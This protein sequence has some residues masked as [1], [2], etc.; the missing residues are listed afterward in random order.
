MSDP[1]TVV[2]TL[3]FPYRRSLGPVIGAF[4][5]AIREHR[6]LGSRTKSG[7]VLVPPHEY[8][9]ETGEAVQAELVEVGPA[10]TVTSWTWVG[11]PTSRHPIS[12][13]FA[14]ALIKL[15]GA[16]TALVHAVDAGSP[17]AMT[18]GM[19]VDPSLARGSRRPRHRHRSLRPGSSRIMSDTAEAKPEPVVVD[20]FCTLTYSDRLS[21]PTVRFAEGLLAGKFIGQKCPACGRVYLPGKGYC[22]IDVVKMDQSTEVN[23]ADEGTVT[24]FTIITPVR[25]FGQT[26]T[27]PFIYASVL[28]DGASSVLGGQEITG[29]PNDQVRVGLRVRAVWKPESERTARRPQPP[30]LG[31]RRR[32]HRDLPMDRRARRG[33]RDVRGVRDLM[34]LNDIAIVGWAQTPS[35]RRTDTTET[36]LCLDAVLG[37]V[38]MAG[39]D[40][41]AIGFTCSGSCDYLTGGPFAFVSNLEAAG[42]WPPISE[43]HVEMDGAWALYE[44]WVRL[45]AGDIDLALVY[46]SGKSSPSDPALLYPQQLD[47]YFLEPLGLDPVSLAGLQARALL[48]SG[49][50]TERDFAEVV[51]RSRRNANGNPNA[52]VRRDD[53]VEELLAKPYYSAPLRAHDLPPISDGAAAVVLATGDQ[54]PGAHRE[55]G[56]HPRHRSPHRAAP[57]RLPRSHEFGLDHVGGQ[58]GRAR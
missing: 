41:R 57:A 31:Q 50:A 37:A 20:R 32:G 10:G 58:A 11:H 8:D 51:A 3:E 53:T 49:K 7:K 44:A 33:P 30:R 26:K 43:S 2:S 9:P 24:G 16:D 4:S 27:E 46:S 21:P 56:V 29:I 15:D 40:R 28:L 12:T 22:P 47:P 17:D 48:D 34:P 35:V 45:H 42:S 18:T 23:V 25:Y 13:P 36:Q 55:P 19:R 1:Y 54:G 6:I 38:A 5:T 14:F 52:Q 39:I